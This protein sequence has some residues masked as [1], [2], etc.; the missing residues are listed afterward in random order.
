MAW[1]IGEFVLRGEIDNRV[2]GKVTGRL[3]L[4]SHPEPLLL[5][6]TGNAGRDLAG[7]CWQFVNLHPRPGQLEMLGP[8][9]TGVLG[10]C[11]ATRKVKVPEVPPREARPGVGAPVLRWHWRNGVF[12]EWF[13]PRNGRVVLASTDYQLGMLS[14][15]AWTMTEAESAAQQRAVKAAQL[16][17]VESSESIW[18]A[19]TR[20]PPGGPPRLIDRIHERLSREGPQADFE[21]IVEEEIALRRRERLSRP[22]APLP[23]PVTQPQNPDHPLVARAHALALRL[24]EEPSSRGWLTDELSPEHPMADQVASTMKAAIKLAGGLNGHPGIIRPEEC[25]AALHWVRQAFEFLEDALCAAEDCSRQ[26]LA[27][28]VW[29]IG[30]RVEL[31]DLAQETA[32]LIEELERRQSRGTE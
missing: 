28:A 20:K 22:P 15:A 25:A 21:R 12:I 18:L 7:R 19:L 6:L 4:T 24:L 29:Q 27:D 1:H 23:L 32:A 14:D 10:E 3:W 30:V 17:A 26:K 5:D 31:T 16:R 8:S 11:T 13:C 2:R 9:L